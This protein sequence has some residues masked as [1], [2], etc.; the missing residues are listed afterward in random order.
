L[1]LILMPNFMFV[2]KTA[3][4]EKKFAFLIKILGAG[5]GERIGEAKSIRLNGKLLKSAFFICE[6]LSE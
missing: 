5:V 2:V 4:H 6:I 1:V 3:V